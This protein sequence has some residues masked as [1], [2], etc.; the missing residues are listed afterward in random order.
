[1]L[2]FCPFVLRNI[3]LFF[4]LLFQLSKLMD[5]KNLK[6]HGE[7]NIFALRLPPPHPDLM[8]EYAPKEEQ[9]TLSLDLG[10]ALCLDFPVLQ[11][12]NGV[13]GREVAGL[14]GAQDNRLLL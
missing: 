5:M 7:K 1:M 8:S 9:I 2:N 12:Q 10:G 3:V 6:S 4:Q 11:G 13:G 14:V